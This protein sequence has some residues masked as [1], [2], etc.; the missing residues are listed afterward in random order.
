MKFFFTLTI[1][2]SCFSAISQ[3]AND[4]ID[5]IVVCGNSNISSNA[6]GFGTQELDG[7]NACLHYEENSLWLSLTIGTGGNLAFNIIPNSTDLVVDYDFYVFGPNNDCGNLDDPIRCNTTNPLKASLNYNETGLRDS[8]T[9][10]SGGPAELGNGYVSS[11]PAKAGEHYYILIDRPVGTGGFI[12]EWTGTAGFLPSPD[13]TEP[14]DIEVCASP[15]NTMIDL[16]KDE[17]SI[18]TSTT[19]NILYFTTYNEAFDSTNAITDPTQFTFNGTKNTI[20]ARVTNPNGCFEIV[21]FNVG[22]TLFDA[23]PN[24]EYTTCDEDGGGQADFSIND[25]STDA[26]NA[27]SNSSAYGLTLH[28]NETAAIANTGQITGTVF[29]SASTTIYARVNATSNSSCYITY[30]ISLTVN[31][32]SFPTS[33]DLIQCDIDQDNSLDGITQINLSQ[34]FPNLDP[35][36]ITYYETDADRTANN[37]ILSPNIYINTTPFNTTIYYKI[38]NSDCD[39]LGEIAIEVKPTTVSLNTISPVMACADN[40]EDE[41]PESTFDLESI[42]QNTYAGM[43]VAFY[44]SLEDA[45]LEQN[46]L[47]GNYRTTSTFLY[48]RLETNNQCNSVEEIEFIVNNLPEITLEDNYEVC[49]DGEPLLI[50]AP[51]GFD[52]YSWLKIENGIPLEISSVQ[53]VTIT[54]PGNYSLEVEIQYQNNNQT[55]SCINYADFLVTPS[56]PV[57]IENIDI[58]QFSNSSTVE[59]EISG[60]SVYEYSLDGMTYQDE[61][62]FDNIEAGFYTVFVRDKNGCGTSQKD[63]SVIGFPKFFTPNGDGANDTWQITGS[64]TSIDNQT[65]NI[66]DRYG[67]LIKQI[68]SNSI[69]WD[70]SLNGQPL[71]SSDYWFRITLTDGKEYKGHFSLKR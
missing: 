67:K 71:P 12:L 64:S 5:A 25:I 48:T 14:N 56:A 57:I 70:G 1:A 33:V 44:E 61:P 43:D 2:L 6:T 32:S 23:P 50:N 28:P 60:D 9:N 41:F 62:R 59:V 15:T 49:A 38:A 45:S 17:A 69:G 22:V 3:Q 35:T 7:E 37:P 31:S 34:S 10:F 42:R 66:Y 63:I 18:T 39:S 13:V 11:I 52:G 29:T 68:S 20:Y 47:D 53:Q 55:A 58:E 24:L 51:D 4:C 36:S 54:E 27:I 30:P 26:E 46:P 8:E 19:A 21:D 16:T 40:P 65:I